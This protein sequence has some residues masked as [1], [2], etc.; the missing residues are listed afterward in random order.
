MI[1][2][3]SRKHL[4]NSYFILTLDPICYTPPD[5]VTVTLYFNMRNS[6]SVDQLCVCVC[7][8]TDENSWIYLKW[9]HILTPLQIPPTNTLSMQ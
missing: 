8:W 7:V 4:S 9:R 2:V 6:F 3:G 1:L 5:F